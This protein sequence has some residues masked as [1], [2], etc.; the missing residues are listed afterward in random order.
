MQFV[1]VSLF[2]SSALAASSSH[3]TSETETVTITSCSAG[4]TDCPASNSTT[5]TST[6][7]DAGVGSLGSYYAAGAAA[8]AAGALLL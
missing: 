1:L 8:L 6:Y 7:V 4:V 2:A 3:F 5:F